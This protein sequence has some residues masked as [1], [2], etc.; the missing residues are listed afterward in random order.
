M[1]FQEIIYSYLTKC[2]KTQQNRTEQNM[3]NLGL[4]LS[5]E[6]FPFVKSLALCIGDKGDH[7]DLST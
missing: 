4:Q 7:P 3:D 5:L 6:S 1:L 2:N